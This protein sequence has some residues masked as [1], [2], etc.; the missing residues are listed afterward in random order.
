MLSYRCFRFLRTVSLKLFDVRTRSSTF[1]IC[2][3][4]SLAGFVVC[5]MPCLLSSLVTLFVCKVELCIYMST[6][7]TLR[8]P[9]LVLPFELLRWYLVF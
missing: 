2:S 1:G 8:S 3:L 9:R 4:T 7:K 5:V 6:N